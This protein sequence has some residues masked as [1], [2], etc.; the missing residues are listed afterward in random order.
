MP[1]TL[2][3]KNLQYLNAGPFDLDLQTGTCL[4]ITG[5]SGIGKSVLLRMLADL[6]PHSGSVSL[7]GV[8][9]SDMPGPAWRRAVR[10][11]ASEPGWWERTVD[12]HFSTDASRETAKALGL[13][14]GVFDEPVDNLSTGE[15][16]RLAFLR[17]IE[18]TPRFLLLDEP[19]S[20]LD[21]T[22]T[23]QVEGII[24]TL[25][26]RDVG[27]IIVSH[28]LEQVAR[29]SHSVFKIGKRQ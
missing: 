25:L 7:D 29:V 22:S 5:P 14:G 24:K 21:Q 17:S 8:N 15:R 6:I 11:H 13:R 26:Q 20:A 16:Q 18:D 1:S 27:V 23:L 3:A 12:S 19:T 4:A 2:S 28:D 9:C 10:Y